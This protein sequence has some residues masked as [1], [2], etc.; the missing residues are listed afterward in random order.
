MT[1]MTL[2]S[3]LAKVEKIEKWKQDFLP[4]D[5]SIAGLADT[6]YYH[7]TKEIEKTMPQ[8]TAEGYLLLLAGGGVENLAETVIT[9]SKKPVL[10]WS[11]AENNALAAALEIVGTYQGRYPLQMVYGNYA[12]QRV[13]DKITTFARVVSL[14]QQMKGI[15]I[16]LFGSPSDWLLLSRQSNIEPFGMLFKHFE[17]AIITSEMKKI[18]DQVAIHFGNQS[19]S[20]TDSTQIIP[21]D[22][23]TSLKAYLAL[24]SIVKT[25]KLDAFTLRCFDLLKDNYTACLA[26]NFFNDEGIPAACEGDKQALVAMIMAHHLTGKPAWMA[27][28][29]S[30]DLENKRIRFAHCTVPLSLLNKDKPIT[31]KTHMES[32]IS[33]AIEGSLQNREVTVFR[34][35]K[36]YERMVAFTGDIIGENEHNPHLCRTQSLV[37][38][39]FEIET[40]LK[41]SAGNHQVIVYGNILPELKLF[42]EFNQM[43]IDLMGN[44]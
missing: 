9:Q 4:D 35:D 24:K 23:I 21:D 34:L 16:G 37:Q 14:M 38:V 18:A 40:W 2:H 11:H 29:S 25:H 42:C 31:L 41:Q 10:L 26:L 32:D 43:K 3:E 12:E 33:V 5:L 1:M 22:I 44:S 19:L 27:N 30:L 20:R 28:P 7:S 13:Q 8:N 15:K 17:T 36:N 6:G 39:D